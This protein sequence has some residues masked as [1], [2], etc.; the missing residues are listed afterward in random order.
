VKRILEFARDELGVKQI[1]GR[2]AKENPASENILKKLGFQYIKDIPYPCNE[3]SVMRE[4]K[5]YMLYF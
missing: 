1:A 4:G 2:H 5:L 3:G